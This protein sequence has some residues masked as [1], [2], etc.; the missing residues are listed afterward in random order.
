[1]DAREIAKQLRRAFPGLF[2]VCDLGD[3]E[4]HLP[5]VTVHRGRHQA[6]V[7]VI[8]QDRNFTGGWTLVE[9]AH[10]NISWTL[11]DIPFLLTIVRAAADSE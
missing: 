5:F 9:M 7:A 11:F 2:V 6:P 4:T 10:P 1:M 8:A 3:R